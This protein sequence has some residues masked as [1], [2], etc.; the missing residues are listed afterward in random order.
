MLILDCVTLKTAPDTKEPQFHNEAF[1]GG[2][3]I[4]TARDF[5]PAVLTVEMLF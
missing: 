2:S 3:S 1:F 4:T 5:L